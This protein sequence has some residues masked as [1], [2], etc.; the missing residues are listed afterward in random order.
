MEGKLV[1]VTG[2]NAGMGLATV[3]ELARMGAEVVMIC[4]SRSRGEAALARAKEESGSKAITLML[5]D[6]GSFASIRGFAE[7]FRNRYDRL[8]VLVN[9]A[10]VVSLKRQST[11]DGYEL[12][13]GVNH[14]GHFLLT[15]ELLPCLLR[16]E[17]GR[18]V[19]VSSGAHKIGR[20]RYDDPWMLSGVNVVNGYARS[21][22]ANI[23]FTKELARRLQGTKVTVNALHPGAVATDIGVDR[24]S[25][26][27]KSVHR[28]L[29]PFFRT[30]LEGAATAIYLASSPDAAR[31]TG[32]YLIDGSPA[33]VA[34]TASDEGE[35]ARL[36]A[37][38]EAQTGAVYS[39]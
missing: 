27:G 34:G 6:L 3:V 20:I 36:W 28:L 13:I 2:A 10:G 4:R 39:L 24:K 23:L 38:S 21:K 35:A 1:A 16:A 37:W 31:M 7:A 32:L 8:D 12:M 5:C 25:G 18:I 29:K 17:Q 22:L 26:F 14:L 19:N 15:G 9:N 11:E 33:R 30:P